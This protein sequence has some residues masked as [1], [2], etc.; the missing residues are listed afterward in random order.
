M[1]VSEDTAAGEDSFFVEVVGPPHSHDR[2]GG[3]QQAGRTRV[4]GSKSQ[5]HHMVGAS[6]DRCRDFPE[7]ASSSARQVRRSPLPD[8]PTAPCL[9]ARGPLPGSTPSGRPGASVSESLRGRLARPDS[10]SER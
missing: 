9:A 1:S 4:L 5:L 7:P 10:A 2:V 3:T 6:A 8:G